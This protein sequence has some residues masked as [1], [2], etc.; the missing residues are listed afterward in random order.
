V[1]TEQISHLVFPLQKGPYPGVVSVSSHS[2]FGFK[3]SR[4]YRSFCTRKCRFV[5]GAHC[6]TLWLHLWFLMP[7][8]GDLGLDLEFLFCFVFIFILFICAYNVWVISSPLPPTPTLPPL[9]P[10]LTLPYPLLA[11]ESILPLSLI[12]LN[13][14]YK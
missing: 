14:E 2:H 13:R 1:T 10:S 11:A 7:S 5:S 12:L 6:L 3:A 9:T 4:N 8:L